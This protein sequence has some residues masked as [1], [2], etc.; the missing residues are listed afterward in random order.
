MLISIVL[1]ITISYCINNTKPRQRGITCLL[2]IIIYSIYNI[3]DLTWLISNSNWPFH[4]SDPTAYYKEV[5]GLQFKDVLS[6]ESSNIFYYIVNWINWKLFDSPYFCSILLRFDNILAYIA[7]YL[8]LTYRNDRFNYIEYL[9]LFN[10]FAIVT[11]VRNVRDVYILIFV[12][13]V[14]IG[15]GL[16]P[17]YRSNKICAFLGIILLLMTRS[18]LLL[19]I[20][21]VYLIHKRDSISQSAKLIIIFSVLTCIV[22]FFPVILKMIANQMIS[23]IDYA[24]EDTE[25]YL[26]LLE[27]NVNFYVIKTVVTRLFIGAVSMLFTPHPIK[28]FH[29]W[30][31]SSEW[32]NFV[33]IYSFPDNCLIYFGSIFNYLFIVPLTLYLLF[34]YKSVNRNLLL[35]TICFIVLYVVAYLGIVDIRNRNTAIF[36]ILASLYYSSEKIQ[37]STK[38]Y[39]LSIAIF[40][41]L[42]IV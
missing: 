36:L 5:V 16:M 15:L 40:I 42:W 7:A 11:I 17:K 29:N 38:Y 37:L 27:G 13:M 9:I 34:N 28:F 32:N 41:G 23:A 19:P 8:I 1:L 6:I 21:I 39:G 25:P 20:A 2:A 35:F 24:D 30:T 31:S 10:P 14:L 18:I 12:L 22:L 26:P 33:G 4:P 3:Y